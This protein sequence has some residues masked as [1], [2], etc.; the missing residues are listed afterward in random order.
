MV[1]GSIQADMVLEKVLRVLHLDSKTTRRYWHSQ[2]ARRK[3]SSAMGK[4]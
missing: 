2:V 1:N 4:A 3:L